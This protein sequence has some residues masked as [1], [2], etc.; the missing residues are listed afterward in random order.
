MCSGMPRVVSPDALPTLVQPVLHQG[1]L[2]VDFLSC[3]MRIHHDEI[4]RKGCRKQTAAAVW[5]S[6][7]QRRMVPLDVNQ[8][9][10]P[11]S[12]SSHIRIWFVRWVQ[13][14]AAAS[15]VAFSSG[16][17]SRLPS[18]SPLCPSPLLSCFILT[19]CVAPSQPFFSFFKLR[20]LCFRHPQMFLV[21]CYNICLV[22]Y[23]SFLFRFSHIYTPPKTPLSYCCASLV[24]L[25]HTILKTFSVM[26]CATLT[27]VVIAVIK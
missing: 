19:C 14:C 8:H 25:F 11:V 4:M 1:G 24:G 26:K 13:D 3:S 7:T 12:N 18:V 5:T 16:F 21:K 22:F 23:V 15:H 9:S 6:A 20:C 27:P 2:I 10:L 17:I